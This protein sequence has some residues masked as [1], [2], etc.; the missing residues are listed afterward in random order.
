[1][2]S[3]VHTRS[4]RVW[5]SLWRLKVPLAVRTPWYRLLQ[6]KLPCA[7][8]IHG[9]INN[10]C[11]PFCCFCAPRMINET[12]DHFFFLC[13]RKRLVWEQIW[14]HF[15]G[16]PMST[17]TVYQAIHLLHFPQQRL[18]L[19]SNESII[20]CTILGIWKAHWRFIFDNTPLDP[21]LVFQQILSMVGPF[22]SDVMTALV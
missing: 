6:G 7:Q 5:G 9:H 3:P 8:V 4:L 15:F 19:I 18:S 1:M 11:D 20:G 13:P 14:W 2:T 22:R 17:H 16:C 21:L 10:I 12:V